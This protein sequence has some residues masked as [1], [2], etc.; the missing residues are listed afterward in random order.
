V[1][2]LIQNIWGNW[3]RVPD[4][5]PPAAPRIHK[6]AT[7]RFNRNPSYPQGGQP[8]QGAWAQSRYSQQQLVATYANT[9]ALTSGT[10]DAL[11]KTS[12][13]RLAV[14]I[15]VAAECPTKDV[16]FSFRKFHLALA[17]QSG[18]G[19][20]AW[21]AIANPVTGRQSV[22]SQAYG[23]GTNRPY[24]DL[25][26]PV[27]AE[28]LYLLRGRVQSTD[29]LLSNFT[30]G[31]EVVVATTDVITLKVIATWEPVQVIRMEELSLL[32]AGCSLQV[33]PAPTVNQSPT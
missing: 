6:V 28:S 11:V 18:S 15:A 13:A 30:N 29:W 16:S 26:R 24:G 17:G 27:T 10:W 9:S 33:T 2:R 7:A 25:F 19:W 22:L 20:G 23:E 12:S 4:P 32:F 21:N 3:V 1:A 8:S 31:T 5:A 14:S